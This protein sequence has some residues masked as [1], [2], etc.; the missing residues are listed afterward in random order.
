MTDWAG[1]LVTKHAVAGDLVKG[2]AALAEGLLSSASR[3]EQAERLLACCWGLPLRG[4]LS[5]VRVGMA[6]QQGLLWVEVSLR[7]LPAGSL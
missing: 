7:Q 6:S 5:Q 1:G 4:L 2:L 3:S